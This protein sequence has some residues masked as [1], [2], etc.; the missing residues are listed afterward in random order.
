M[1]RADNETTG[2]ARSAIRYWALFGGVVL[3]SLV[4]LTG[5]SAVASLV[6]GRPL[7]GEF[8]LVRHG[9]AI[10]AF[11]F[12]PYAQLTGANVSVDLFTRG[13]SDRAKAVME[14]VSSVVVIVVAV[15]LFRQM[16]FGMS[17]YVNYPVQM[18]TVPVPL[19]TAFPP[20]LISL[21]LL[22]LA[23]ILTGKDAWRSARG[24]AGP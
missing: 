9:V 8:E 2:L 6:I 1:E 4:A 15:V 20:M 3:L 24:H 11:A 21:V 12:L 14:I 22:A 23:A 16:W 19:W 7:R 13:M 10:A 17:D 18:V 5:V